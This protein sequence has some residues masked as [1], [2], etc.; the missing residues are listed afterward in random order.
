ME[1]EKLKELVLE[2]LEKGKEG[3]YWDLMQEWYTDTPDL[4]KDIICFT[5]TVHDKD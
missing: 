4:L 1:I 2:L 3:L 5:N